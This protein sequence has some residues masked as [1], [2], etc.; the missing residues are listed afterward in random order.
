MNKSRFFNNSPSLTLLFVLLITLFFSS[1][2]Q[3]GKDKQ[4]LG[5]LEA[6]A[7]GYYAWLPAGFVYHD[8]NFAFTS[9]IEGEKYE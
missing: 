7:R 5:I 2:I 6:D 1:N 4:H 8:L 3:W 9:K